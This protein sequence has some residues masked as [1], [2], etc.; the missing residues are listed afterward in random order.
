VTEDA[1]VD[2]NPVWSADGATLAFLSD[3]GG[4]AGL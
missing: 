4:T 1:A 3:R 2:W